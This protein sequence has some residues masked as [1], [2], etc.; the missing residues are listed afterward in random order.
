MRRRRQR[1]SHG[2]GE[3]AGFSGLIYCIQQ[4][5]MRCFDAVRIRL[6]LA[7]LGLA[8]LGS[9][10]CHDESQTQNRRGH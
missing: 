7:L 8:V 10:C 3:L 1:W 2:F 6:R 5:A 4:F 9:L